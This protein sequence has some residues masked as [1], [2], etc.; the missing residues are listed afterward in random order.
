MATGA[1][2]TGKIA[3]VMFEGFL[4]TFESQ[5][6]LLPLVRHWI[7]NAADLQN[8]GNQIWRQV[9][10]HAP[11]IEG[12]DLTGLETGIIQQT[13]P[14]VLGT[15]SN[16]FVSQRADDLRDEQFWKERAETSARR[17]ASNLNSKIATAIA[18]QGSLFYRSSDASGFDFI[19]EAQALMNERQ[20][21]KNQRHYLL[22]D[23]DVK[24]FGENLA[25]RQTLQ[26]RAADTWLTGQIGAN[27]AEFDLHVGSFLPNLAGGASPATTVTGNQSFAPS[28][29][30][31]NTTTNV[32]TNVDYRTA[33][34][35]VAASGSYNV[36]DKVYFT[37]GGTPV[38]ALGL[39]DKT[40]TTSPMTFSII[41]KPNAT[42]IEVFP[43]PIAVDDPA[44]STLEAAYANINTRILNGAVVVR[45]NT[46]T[47]VR[48]NLFW[49]KDAIEVMGGEI[50]TNMFKELAGK[51]VIMEKMKNG[52][53]IYMVYDGSILD[54]TFRYRLFTWFGITVRKPH[55]CGVSVTYD[56]T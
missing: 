40:V 47:S 48:T 6:L 10:Q 21:V 26:G 33:T 24:R 52:Q 22:N 15:P 3:L 35:A 8:A 12:W 43:R 36:G 53:T 7:P 51:K 11:I 16:D 25:G 18:Q 49:D 14:A 4:E 29:G 56:G 39:D 50:P 28:A 38:Y 5:Q 9:D 42:S 45:M 34:I 32:V 13:Y 41:S 55:A 27:V 23:R 17:Q 37:N 31:V 44:L 54:M 20:L 1:L 2:T 46:D 30:T 19:S